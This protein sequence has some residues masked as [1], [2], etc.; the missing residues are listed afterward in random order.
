[1]LLIHEMS[2]QSQCPECCFKCRC[3]PPYEEL[4][5]SAAQTQPKVHFPLAS[6]S[7]DGQKQSPMKSHHWLHFLQSAMSQEKVHHHPLHTHLSLHQYTY[8]Y[9][10]RKDANLSRQRK[11]PV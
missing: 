7:C 5:I 10:H 8:I 3:R 9:T 1:M 6:Q 11:W 2:S 4:R